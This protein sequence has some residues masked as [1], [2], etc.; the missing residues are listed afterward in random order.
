MP[1]YKGEKKNRAPYD[2]TKKQIA[3]NLYGHMQHMPPWHASSK[4]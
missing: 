3:E 1:E 4:C 2:L